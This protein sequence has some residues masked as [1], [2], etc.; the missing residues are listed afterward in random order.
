MKYV[1]K[2]VAF[3]LLGTAFFG[4]KVT[5][6]ETEYVDRIVEVEKEVPVY[7]EY[8]SSVTFTATGGEGAVS[9]EMASETEGATIYYTNDDST[10]TTQSA[11]YTGAVEITEITTFKAIAV[12]DGL[13]NSPV[14]YARFSVE[15]KTATTVEIEYQDRIVEKEY[16]SAVEFT[17]T[18][19]DTG[20]E[21]TLSTATADATIH[22]TT[23]GTTPSANSTK[24][25]AA[26][27]VSENTTI[28][29]IAIKDGIEDSPVSVATV[30]IKKISSTSGSSGNPLSIALTSEVP[31]LNGYTGTKSNTSVTVT[32]KITSADTIKEVV[33]KKNGSLI[34]KVLLA[35]SGATAATVDA[36]DNSTWTFTISA[37]DETANGTYTVAAIDEAGREEAE[38]ITLD[39]FDFTP[40]NKVSGV[41]GTIVNI[42]GT[43]TAVLI[44]SE[45]TATD[46]DHVEIAYIYNN[47]TTDSALNEYAVMEKG[48]TSYGFEVDSGNTSYTFYIVSVDAVGNR[49]KAKEFA[50][51]VDGS[52][53]LAVP[54]GFV[55]VNGATVS[56]RVSTSNVFITN[57][58]VTIPD[59][60]V[61]DHEVTQGEYEEFCKYGPLS[62]NDTSG[63]GDN[64]PAYDVSWYDAIVYCNLR[65]IDE[66]LTPV[67]KI[68]SETDPSKWAS[69]V[70]ATTD[71]VTKYCG[72]SSTNSTWDGVTCDFTANGYRLPTEAEWEYIA[73]GGNNGI[74]TTQTTYSGSDTIGDV[75]WYKENSDSKTH[76][77]KTKAANT[78]GIYDMSGNV[79]EWCWDWYGDISS[80]TAASG[81]SS[82]YFRTR[83]GGS[84]ESTASYCTVSNAE[85]HYPFSPN[86]APGFRVVRTVQ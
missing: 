26:I 56:G 54:K 68:G 85:K 10:P 60:Y 23:D 79:R 11:K 72:P 61:C 4:C 3:L 17:A 9:V 39:C 50:I 7:K 14:A 21:L 16:A 1:S 70:S 8:A 22:Y 52:L 25:T 74:P 24:Y 63:K 12:K 57:R 13:E 20:V 51:N 84:W 66:C 67:Y 73:R 45:P 19:T 75:A 83:R 81:L 38:E 71:G 44:W 37:T 77:V 48:T 69:I 65:S 58:T 62:P 46:F 31:Q 6:T 33:W 42:V 40:P 55:K 43:Q 5:E 78:L 53:V 15:T 30:R 18:D 76:E 41:T 2:S 27:A 59:M 28:K 36:S 64:Y 34:A 32:A 29:A 35:D 47:G 80:S 86:G 82:G 49:S